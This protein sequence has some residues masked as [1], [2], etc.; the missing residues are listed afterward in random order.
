M[1]TERRSKRGV[2]RSHLAILR[3]LLFF[4]VFL[5]LEILFD[6]RQEWEPGDSS[7]VAVHA[8]E[9]PS[10][11][12]TVYP[13]LTSFLLGDEPSGKVA[14]VY[15][16]ENLVEV[17]QNVCRGRIYMAAL[18]NVLRI[19]QPSFWISTSAKSPVNSIRRKRTVRLPSAKPF[20]RR[21][22]ASFS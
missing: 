19:P 4:F 9:V 2:R 6:N 22:P 8:D 1:S 12:E 7:C 15:V 10:H 20:R 18:I 16:P 17:Q 5:G 13:W 14:V 11:Y 3:A 21:A